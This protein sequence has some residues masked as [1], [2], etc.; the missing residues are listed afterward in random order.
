[1][2]PFGA[3]SRKDLIRG[4]R[5]A[6]FDGPYA[7]GKHPFM[8]RGDVTLAIPNPH[9]GDIG[10]EL[11]ARILRQAGV[12]RTWLTT[13]CT[14]AASAELLAHILRWP[15]M[16]VPLEWLCVLGVHGVVP[17]EGQFRE[18]VEIQWGH[19]LAG[20]E[21][22]RA[23]SQVREH[24]AGLY[25]VEVRAA[26]LDAD[27]DW[28]AVTQPVEGQPRSNWQVPYDER[29]LEKGE[30]RWAFFFHYLDLTRPLQT[31]VG[32]CAL[33]DPTPTPP[34]LSSIVYEVPG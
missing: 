19:D 4:L 1:M 7:G 13:G 12:G 8:I 17:T 24:F 29:R 3:I 25:L 32:D 11:L 9:H 22:A 30:D 27:I 26:P 10:R 15:G 31:Q 21:L 18:T 20:Q 33:P 28:G 2:P 23:E 14:G 16:G 6:G 34:H 5:A